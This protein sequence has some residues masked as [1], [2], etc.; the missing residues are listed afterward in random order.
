MPECEKTQATFPLGLEALV[1]IYDLHIPLLRQH[2]DCWD[3]CPIAV[4]H[5]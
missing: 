5:I 4:N 1:K 3:T 2:L